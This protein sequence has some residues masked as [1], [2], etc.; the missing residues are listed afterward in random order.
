MRGET[1]L[2]LAVAKG[3][4][5]EVIDLLIAA[6]A[7]PN[8]KASSGDYPLH[9][10]S[11]ADV[12]LRLLRAGARPDQVNIF[13]ISPL[14]RALEAGRRDVARTLVVE[15]H[16]AVTV[17]PGQLLATSPLVHAVRTG[18]T[19]LVEVMLAAGAD[20]M[21]C[22][23]DAFPLTALQVAAEEG[24][25]ALGTRLLQ[26]KCHRAAS[27]SGMLDALREAW[28][29][30][31]QPAERDAVINDCLTSLVPELPRLDT[32]SH[33]IKYFSHTS[34]LAGQIN[35]VRLGGASTRCSRSGCA[36]S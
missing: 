30:A 1:A 9:V 21:A 8:A 13:G 5:L 26:W 12:A 35:S 2:W 7:D 22:Q 25:V 36:H 32:E 14:V 15:G 11:R 19:D 20:P 10:V 29:G 31:S 24:H 6:G 33:R 4:S 17:A 16:A 23:R 34:Q 28:K 3:A 18:D 27:V